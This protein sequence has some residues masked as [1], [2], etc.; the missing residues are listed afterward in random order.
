MKERERVYLSQADSL[1]ADITKIVGQLAE[2]KNSDKTETLEKMRSELD[3]LVLTN[4]EHLTTIDRLNLE[5]ERLQKDV[6]IPG[7]LNE[8][9][10]GL[11]E[12]ELAQ[13]K[14]QTDH[15]LKAKDMEWRS[16][17][18]L[19]MKESD[20]I[21]QLYMDLRKN[22]IR[23]SEQ[24][25]AQK[26][27][28]SILSNER[29][30]ILSILK[31]KEVLID[32]LKEENIKFKVEKE[33]NRGGK[34]DC[35]SEDKNRIELLEREVERLR[36]ELVTLP[37]RQT[38]EL[39]GLKSELDSAKCRLLDLDKRLRNEFE[40]EISSLIEERDH[41]KEAIK[42]NNQ[43]KPN[44]KIVSFKDAQVETDFIEHQENVLRSDLAH[45]NK[46]FVTCPNELCEK[47]LL[48][49][50][51]D[52]EKRL[53][54]EH[55]AELESTEERIKSITVTYYTNHIEEIKKHFEVELTKLIENEQKKISELAEL[56]SKKESEI[57]RLKSNDFSDKIKLLQKQI[58]EDRLKYTESV[59]H[60]S[61]RVEQ[62]KTKMSEDENKMRYLSQSLK[63]ERK[64]AQKYK[65]KFDNARKL[66][67]QEKLE[68]LL[69][70][71]AEFDH[72]K[73]SNDLD[74]KRMDDKIKMVELE[75]EERQKSLR[76]F[77]TTGA[78]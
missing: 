25:E 49:E 42:K 54:S 46:D 72:L 11:R 39:E 44:G 60:W 50:L 33:L 59:K 3:R 35:S 57:Q 71:K 5:I 64:D 37:K 13:L 56:L 29:D 4:Q 27:Q 51:D 41:L 8:K 28:L 32:S 12:D 62:M 70:I 45:L 2:S 43:S 52:L 34:F 53:I 78:V 65:A 7:V 69:K 40:N 66:I 30:N 76:Q 1:K 48:S 61:N 68:N 23:L 6:S 10:V 16:R 47:K 14:R 9:T 38:K 19:V 73:N 26:Q 55:K 77:H 21:K 22:N 20:E 75:F 36:A 24:L 17:M 67:Q 63:T 15:L 18:E 31:E 74:C 58:E